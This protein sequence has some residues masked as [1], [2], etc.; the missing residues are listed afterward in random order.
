MKHWTPD[1]F[2]QWLYGLRPSDTH[3]GECA[4]CGAEARRLTDRRQ[5]LAEASAEEEVSAELLA[6]QRRGVYQRLGQSPVAWMPRLQ[7]AVL[8]L[9][10]VVVALT[11]GLRGTRTP[12]GLGAPADDQLFSDLAGIEQSSEP[13]AAKPIHNLFEE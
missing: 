8:A 6:A 12:A 3:L 13:R 9:V 11:F 4:Q 2:T 5:A 1:E 10:I 7:A